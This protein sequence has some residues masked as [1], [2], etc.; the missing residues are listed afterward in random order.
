MGRLK[1]IRA[2]LDKITPPPW[3]Q[4]SPKDTFEKLLSSAQ[5]A[6]EKHKIQKTYDQLLIDMD[7]TQKAPD[8]IAYLLS[9]VKE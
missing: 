2:R 5:T 8:D 6:A 7:F 4:A 9:L 3:N 1:E